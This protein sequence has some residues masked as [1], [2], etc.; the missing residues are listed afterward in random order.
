MAIESTYRK[1]LISDYI[2]EQL[3]AGRTVSALEIQEQ[4]E[5]LLEERDLSVPQ[6]VASGYYV[7]E[8]ESSSA[9]KHVNTFN[10]IRQDL[11][12]LYKEMLGLSKVSSDA[13]ER[14][15]LESDN[16]EKRL[17]DLEDRI[18]D[19]LLL[20]QDTE[21]HHSILID[22]FTDTNL[23]DS[24]LTTAE[25]DLEGALVQMGT[26]DSTGVRIFLNDLDPATDV[27]FKIRSTTNFINRTDA[28][29]ASLVDPFHQESKAWWTS[30]AMNKANPVTCEFTIKLGDDP[31]TISKIFMQLHESAESSPT[32]ITPLYSVDNQIFEQLPTNTFTQEV[33][34]S[35]T[36]QF[37]EVQAKWIKFILTKA[38]PDPS[39]G[40]SY[41]YYE[42]GFKQIAFYHDAF[43][44]DVVQRLVTAPLWVATEDGSAQ[45]F[46]K[47]TLD[48][49]ERLETDTT[50]KYFV[51]T[52]ND[53]DSIDTNFDYDLALWIPISPIGRE[54]ALHPLVLDVGDV[55]ETVIGDT[56][57]IQIAYDGVATDDKLINP[58]DPFRLLSKDSTT[59][60]V[61]DEEV[62][63]KDYST[64]P[65]VRY[66][67][68]NTNDRILNYQIKDTSYSGS[69]TGEALIINE[70]TMML[71]RNIGEVGLT[72]K[73]TT[74][75]VR[76]V[77][78]G[79][80]FED[81]YYS[82]IVEIRNPEGIA[83]DVGDSP[84]IIDDIS[85]T[86]RVDETVLTGRTTAST[87][88][89]S[90]QV[91]KSNWKEVTPNLG[92]PAAGGL[93]DIK[94]ADS[95]YPYNH[96]LLIEGYDYHDDFIDTKVYTGVDLFAETLMSQ[97]SIFDLMNNITV[98]NYDVFALDRDAPNSHVGG[99]S[100]TRVFVLKIDE[101][102]PDFQ[103]ERFMIRFTLV[104]Q[105]QKYLRLRVD[106]STADNKVTPALHS[107][108]VKLG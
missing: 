87:G 61:V 33:R 86:N 106:F 9:V 97:V 67:F 72:P 53:I 16:I 89:H 34:T 70:A 42:F 8:G 55:A 91:H 75:L 19:L 27:S 94:K 80:R 37:S 92:D 66:A 77:Q 35:T 95:L 22:N 76:E 21:G 90:I 30:I 103:N 31:V 24:D 51:T 73:D 46:E 32:N 4:V 45:N 105:L 12:V 6:F 10:T 52:S 85:Y 3:R 65:V 14:W 29:G 25:V 83:I 93:N 43:D 74:A 64:T 40:T 47:L 79:W 96:K 56:E 81:P 54:L 17:I 5:A 59:A 100:P 11:R 78:R 102:N 28:T 68:K 60:A 108:K 104:N 48:V 23:V 84:I 71:F 18:E 82:C 63:T 36:F 1:L 62:H 58:S 88:L 39:S 57:T 98:D 44:S 69:G 26:T 99:N 2:Y 41:F 101:N 107:Y 49:C 38:G 13:F 7:T 50:I 15:G 20:T